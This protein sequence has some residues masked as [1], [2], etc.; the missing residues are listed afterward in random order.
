MID[1][2]KRPGRERTHWEREKHSK[3]S[4]AT[5]PRMH[6]AHIFLFIWSVQTG[7]YNIQGAVRRWIESKQ[8]PRPTPRNT[9]GRAHSTRL[10]GGAACV[11]EGAGDRAWMM[12]VGCG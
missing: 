7:F 8:T 2:L 5:I 1:L 4:D 11:E 10:W 9:S 12:R 3:K 6:R